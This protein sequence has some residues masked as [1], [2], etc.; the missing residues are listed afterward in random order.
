[1]GKFIY[2]YDS[3][4]KVKDMLEKKVQKELAYINEEIENRI[5]EY[6]KL[7]VEL[8][9]SFFNI[10]SNKKVSEMKSLEDYRKSLVKRIES[11]QSKIKLLEIRKENTLNDLIEKSKEKKIFDTLEE[12]H[13]ENY[14]DEENTKEKNILNEIAIQKFIKEKI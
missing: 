5:I 10:L 13:F 2:K 1:M 14:Q 4:K 7:I 3:V 9:I 8:E 11:V 12:A 6:E